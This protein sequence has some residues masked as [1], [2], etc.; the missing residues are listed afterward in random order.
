MR[1][2]FCVVGCGPAGAAAALALCRTGI[3]PVVYEK[4]A[5]PR[6]KVCGEFFSAEILPALERIG[7]AGRF[8]DARPPRVTHGELHFARSGRRFP[9]P[10]TGFGLSRYTFDE[11]LCQAVMERAAEVRHERLLKP[12]GPAVWAAGRGAAGP[13]GRRP[14]GFKAH[15]AGPAGDAVELYFF[16]GGYCGTCPI[17][18]GLTNVCGLASEELLA[19][20]QFRPD[21]MLRTAGRLAERLRPLER[22]TLWRFSGP[23]RYGPPPPPRDGMIAAGDAACFVD[24][25]TGSGLLAAI[26]T[27][28]WAGE[29]LLETGRAAA[30]HLRCRRFQRRQLTATTLIRRAVELGWAEPLAGLIPSSV[31]YRLTRP[32]PCQFRS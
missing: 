17:E 32:A 31:L 11:M 20:H 25:F 21:S 23:L 24:P 4:S 19:A 10:E 8:M 16:P 14:F 3:R 6:H 30:H 26:E 27:G 18:N 15:F 9:L 5:F 1:E 29:T 28:V 22:R 13:R 7:M 2:E 12:T